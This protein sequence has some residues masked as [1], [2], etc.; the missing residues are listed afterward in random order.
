[1]FEVDL[2]EDGTFE[3]KN[4]ETK[5]VVILRLE[6]DPSSVEAVET[7]LANLFSLS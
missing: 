6:G 4:L 2:H 1:M 7:H 5:S 3:I